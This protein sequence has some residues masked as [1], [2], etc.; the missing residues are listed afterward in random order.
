M[1][2]IS[3]ILPALPE[4]VGYC[5][6][7]GTAVA[8]ALLAIPLGIAVASLLVASAAIALIRLLGFRVLRNLASGRY[9]RPFEEDRPASARVRLRLA[10]S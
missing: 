9:H 4:E 3:V 8:L 2:I 6:T 10:A 5:S 7:P 1:R